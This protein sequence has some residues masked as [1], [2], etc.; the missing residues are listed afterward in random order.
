MKKSI[1]SM[2]VDQKTKSFFGPKSIKGMNIDRDAK[3]VTSL[4]Y[5]D[6]E[7]AI[8][9]GS[10]KYI[11][12]P[13]QWK[14]FKIVQTFSEDYDIMNNDILA[15]ALSALLSLDKYYINNY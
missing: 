1:K 14:N 2:K 3:I 5:S 6:I 13:K 12:R 15:K 7:L 4:N 9:H 8:E 10:S 11:K